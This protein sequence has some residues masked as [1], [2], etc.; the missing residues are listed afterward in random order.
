MLNEDI[1]RRRIRRPLTA[2]EAAN[3]IQAAE[4]GPWSWGGLDPIERSSTP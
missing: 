2:D 3:L 1:D 4:S